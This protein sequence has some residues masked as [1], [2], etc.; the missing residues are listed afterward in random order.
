MSM[1][2][3]KTSQIICSMLCLMALSGITPAQACVS[4]HNAR[5]MIEKY[6]LKTI[7]QLRSRIPGQILSVKLCGSGASAEYHVIYKQSGKNGHK[8]ETKIISAR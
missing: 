1:T 2:F 8:R 5:P 7:S 6:G 4:A 3:L